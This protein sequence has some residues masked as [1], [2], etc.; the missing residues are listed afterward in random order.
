MGQ[1]A[2]GLL[3]HSLS[4]LRSSLQVLLPVRPLAP[5]IQWHQHTRS[6][7]E[8][9]RTPSWIRDV[10]TYWSK[11]TQLSCLNNVFQQGGFLV[12][13]RSAITGSAL[14]ARA[15]HGSIS[16]PRSDMRKLRSIKIR[17]LTSSEWRPI[18]PQLPLH[19]LLCP[20]CSAHRWPDR[21]HCCCTTSQVALRSQ[22]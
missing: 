15:Q 20:V 6:L 11:L 14:P 4:P 3:I 19:L 1:P 17:W 21:C 2:A 10:S 18:C 13:A 7:H 22:H 5:S 9:L 8:H 12:R 16:A